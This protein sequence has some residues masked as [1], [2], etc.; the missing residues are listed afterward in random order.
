MYIGTA[1]TGVAPGSPTSTPTPGARAASPTT[2]DPYFFPSTDK[3]AA[4]EAVGS[5]VVTARAIL[6]FLQAF[7]S[8]VMASFSVG[9]VHRGVVQ[10]LVDRVVHPRI[11]DLCMNRLPGAAALATLDE[12]CAFCG[13]GVCG[14][15]VAGLWIPC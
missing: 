13:G 15:G 5:R 12:R 9:E 10:G 3:G 4:T 7:T 8:Q 14:G 1:S 11:N 6:C 2:P